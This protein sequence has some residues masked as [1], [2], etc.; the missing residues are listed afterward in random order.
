MT[1]LI[2]RTEEFRRLHQAGCFVIPNPW[3]LGSARVLAQLGFPALATTSSGFAWAGG[4]SDNDGPLEN[5]LA[6]FEQLAEGVDVPVS[7]DFQDCFATDPSGVE[8]NVRAAAATGVAGLSIED[9]TRNGATPLVEFPLAVER[10]QAAREAS[11]RSG[12][13]LVLTAAIR[14]LHRRSARSR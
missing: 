8:K 7:A 9:S 12:V 11:Q 2:Q 4:Q 3:D 10:V 14:G 5:A 13:R 6:H 1:T